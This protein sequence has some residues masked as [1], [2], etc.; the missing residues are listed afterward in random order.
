MSAGVI[1]W[2][3]PVSIAGKLFI[4]LIQ[5]DRLDE[6]INPYPAKISSM[7]DSASDY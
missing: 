2:Q 7:P 5:E 4:K 1:V 3:P 6:A